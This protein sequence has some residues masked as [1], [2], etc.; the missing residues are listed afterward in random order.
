MNSQ[1]QPAAPN[2]GAKPRKLTVGYRPLKSPGV[3][4]PYLRLHGRWL[5]AAGFEVGRS[6]RVEGSEGRLTI[7]RID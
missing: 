1:A 2:T 6:V 7:E 3:D 4:V 5:R